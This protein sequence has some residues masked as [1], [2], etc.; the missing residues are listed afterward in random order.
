M[1]ALLRNSGA[2]PMAGGTDLIPSLREHVVEA[3]S[4]VDLSGIA[5]LRGIVWREDGGVEIGAATSL[6]AVADDAQVRVRYPALAE[7]CSLVGSPA[8]RNMGTLGGNLCQ[9]PRCWYFRQRLPCH[10][11]G[12]S[13]CFAYDG[14]NEYHAILGGGPCYIVH[15]SDAAVA[16]MALGATVHVTGGGGDR[17]M[18]I[19][20]FFVLPAQ[21]IDGENVLQAGEL[22]RS[23]E[24]PSRSSGGRQHFDKLM[25]RGAWDFAVVSVAGARWPDGTVR[26]VLGGVA[27]IPWR[28]RSSIEEDVASGNLAPDDIDTLAERALYDAQPLGKNGYKVDVALALLRRALTVLGSPATRGQG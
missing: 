13:F 20:E 2:R 15:P 23:I 28:V 3:Q 14:E 22:V 8:L 12:G 27:P 4:L 9:R 21:R 17:T 19:D 6:T 25:Q 10:K 11:H 16:L 26:L 1:V 7:A 24:L 5:E 18:P